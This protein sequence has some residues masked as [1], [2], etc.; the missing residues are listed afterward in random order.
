MAYNENALCASNDDTGCI[1]NEVQ[2]NS[3]E[4]AVQRGQPQASSE[5]AQDIEEKTPNSGRRLLLTITKKQDDSGISIITQSEVYSKSRN[6]TLGDTDILEKN[7]RGGLQKPTDRQNELCDSSKPIDQRPVGDWSEIQCETVRS[8][9]N[10]FISTAADQSDGF[11]QET[12]WPLFIELL[13]SGNS[14]IARQVILS[15]GEIAACRSEFRDVCITQG[16]MQV[17]DRQIRSDSPVGVLEAIGRCMVN[18]FASYVANIA[19]EAIADGLLIIKKLLVSQCDSVLACICWTL[20]NIAQTKNNQYIQ[21]VI[22]LG[23][24]D[25]LIKLIKVSRES[26][27]IRPALQILCNVVAI[28]GLYADMVVDMGA[29]VGFRRLLSDKE[30]NSCEDIVIWILMQA[31]TGRIAEG[32]NRRVSEMIRVGLVPFVLELLQHEDE[33][34][35]EKATMTIL[36]ITSYRNLKQMECFLCEKALIPLIGAVK[37]DINE[38]FRINTLAALRNV[39]MVSRENADEH[40]AFW[41]LLKKF[42]LLN[43]LENKLQHGG[44]RQ[45]RRFVD[46]ACHLLSEYSD[47]GQKHS[48]AIF[49]SDMTAMFTAIEHLVHRIHSTSLE[50]VLSATYMLRILSGQRTFPSYVFVSLDTVPRLTELLAR[51]DCPEV[52]NDV[53]AVLRN[54]SA[55]GWRNRDDIISKGLIPELIRLVRRGLS[56]HLLGMVSQCMAS[57]FDHFPSLPP[58]TI[59]NS[60]LPLIRL[61]LMHESMTVVRGGEMALWSITYEN[62]DYVQ[63]VVNLGVLDRLVQIIDSAYDQED[64]T[65]VLQILSNIAATSKVHAQAIVRHGALS[66]FRRLV[67]DDY[68]LAKYGGL[69]MWILSHITSHNDELNRAVIDVGFAFLF[70]KLIRQNEDKELQI[71]VMVV[72]YNITCSHD[73]HC[74]ESLT[75]TGILLPLTDLAM[76]NADRTLTY[77]ARSTL[78]NISSAI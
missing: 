68:N 41:N 44:N 9:A 45:D 39:L 4:S 16:I 43:Y 26:D 3:Q 59:V 48:I 20:S 34:V 40:Q 76:N 37:Y 57:L 1:Q 67:L 74:I 47:S 13:G 27:L 5:S 42:G 35:R 65:L 31:S 73:R 12:I 50:T 62:T 33:N 23:I 14:S 32:E 51:D 10:K 71:N 53:L 72:I 29:L 28:N 78:T 15:I 7:I 60:C 22:D 63:Q 49:P 17:L 77:Y 24:L 61:F 56:D 64:V 69:I 46:I 36:N 58:A 8:M 54:I 11:L 30:L 66:A 6:I 70:P 55:T 52:Q 38:N 25:R 75:Q 18:L 21:Q 19:P 2:I